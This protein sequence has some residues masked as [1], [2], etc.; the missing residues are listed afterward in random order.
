MP[1]NY[2][3]G[4]ALRRGMEVSQSQYVLFSDL[5]FPYTLESLYAMID[6]LINDKS[7]VVIGKRSG[8]YYKKIPTQRRVIS[9]WVKLFNKLFFNIPTADTQSGLKGMNAKGKEQFLLTKTNRYLIDLE[10]LKRTYSI[11][12]ISISAIPIELRSGIVLNR[13]SLKNLMRELI[14]YLKILFLY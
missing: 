9:K 6:I 13:M 5:D 3:K 14:S 7:D 1:Q 4:Y 11:Q 2:G 8:A 10:F 12:T